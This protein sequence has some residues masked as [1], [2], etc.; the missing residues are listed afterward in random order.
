MAGTSLRAVT[1]GYRRWYRRQTGKVVLEVPKGI[2]IV[3]EKGAKMGKVS[4]DP[5]RARATLEPREN[6]QT[7]E[8]ILFE[9]MLRHQRRSLPPSLTAL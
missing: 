7:N 6:F 9:I 3:G 8:D 5:P 1:S 2:V 4:F